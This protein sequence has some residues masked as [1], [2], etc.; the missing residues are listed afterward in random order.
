M[1]LTGTTI[2]AGCFV[3]VILGIAAWAYPQLPAMAPTHWD[4]AGNVN[5]WMPRFWAVAVPVL[6]MLGLAIMTPLLPRISPR[7]FAITPFARVY[8]VMML[9]IQALLLVVF[10]AALLA[11]TGRHVPIVLIVTLAVGAL[12]MILGN[13]MGKLRKNFFIG[14]RTPWTLASDA[15]WERTQRLAGWLFVLAGLVWIVAGFMHAPAAVLVAAV[16]V[17]AF[18]PAAGSYFIYRRLE[19]RPHAG[20]TRK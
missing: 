9:A 17:A 8:G 12:L 13:Y 18:V 2:V 15:V 20:G 19:G 11:G 6:L 1:K 16:L 10:A 3:V 5:G 14:I 7:R 4:A